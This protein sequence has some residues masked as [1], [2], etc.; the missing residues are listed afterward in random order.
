MLFKDQLNLFM[1][2]TGCTA[3]QL[4]VTS[5]ISTATLWRYRNGK[6]APEMCG[7]RMDGI[8][9][10]LVQLSCD[11]SC[12]LDE[13]MVRES[14]YKCDDI[15]P[16]DYGM[17]LER[18]N[19]LIDELDLNIN[20]LCQSAGYEASSLFRI[21]KGQRKPSNPVRLSHSIASYIVEVHSDN[22]SLE[23]LEK[24]IPSYAQDAMPQRIESIINWLMEGEML[25]T[26][27]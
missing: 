10:A 14:F 13:S 6:S 24:L 12:A 21:R 1:K 16:I 17:F 3:K 4:S 22:T 2:K 7:D 18:L 25:S 5:G 20:E 26:D 8:V 15:Y 11:S 27:E 9:K 19:L 23:K